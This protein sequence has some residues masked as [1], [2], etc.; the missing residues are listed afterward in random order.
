MIY[1][2]RTVIGTEERKSY[3]LGEV[4]VAGQSARQERKVLLYSLGIFL[5]PFLAVMREC[6]SVAIRCVTVT[7]ISVGMSW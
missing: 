6:V 5:P 7:C 1:Y 3:S 2:G 4:L